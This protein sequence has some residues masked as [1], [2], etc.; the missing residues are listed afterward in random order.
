MSEITKDLLEEYISCQK[1]ILDIQEIL[2]KK[3][4]EIGSWE[5]ENLDKKPEIHKN[6]SWKCDEIEIDES[7]V[8]FHIYETWA[9]GGYDEKNVC[10]PTNKFI[11]DDWRE[12]ALKEHLDKLEQECLEKEKKEKEELTKRLERE[13]LEYERLKAIFG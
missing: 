5:K 12:I 7:E 9:Y 11:S 4:M 2:Y 8:C 6:T 1:R 3:A 10:I 13:R